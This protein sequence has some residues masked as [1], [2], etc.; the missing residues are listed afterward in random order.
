MEFTEVKKEIKN[1]VFDTLRIESDNYFEAVILK[2]ELSQLMERLNKVFGVPVWPSSKNRL[3][4][5]IEESVRN[6]GGV[7]GNQTLYYSNQAGQT[8]FAMLWPWKDG[9]RTTVKL[10]KA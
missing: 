8:L 6:Y 4:M 7:I 10:V 1:V 3:S 9:E 2:D 5:Q